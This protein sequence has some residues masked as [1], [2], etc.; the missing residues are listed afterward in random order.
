MKVENI[1]KEIINI[2]PIDINNFVETFE[3]PIRGHLFEKLFDLMQRINFIKELEEYQP[4]YGNFGNTNF[5]GSVDIN[6]LNFLNENIHNGNKSGAI[7]AI[8][9]NKKEKKIIAL[10]FKFF[11]KGEP[12]YFKDYDINGMIGAAKNDLQNEFKD[13]EISFG[14]VTNCL[15]KGLKKKFEKTATKSKH[16]VD[17][18]FANPEI[19][20]YFK[21]FVKFILDNK[22]NLTESFLNKT[23]EKKSNIKLR[24]YQDYGYKCL[25]KIFKRYNQALLGALPRFGKTLVF[26]KMM[27]DYNKILYISRVVSNIKEDLVEFIKNNEDFDKY[28][29]SVYDNGEILSKLELEEKH[30]VI[31]SVQSFQKLES[32][33]KFDLIIIDEAHIGTTTENFQQL[34]KTLCKTNTKILFVTATFKKPQMGYDLN[35][36]QCFFFGLSDVAKLHKDNRNKFQGQELIQKIE[37]VLNRKITDTEFDEL[38]YPVIH[39]LNLNIPE[40]IIKEFDEFDKNE[41]TF[42]KNMFKCDDKGFT[43]QGKEGITNILDILFKKNIERISGNKHLMT[44]INNDLNLV[45]FKNKMIIIYVPGGSEEMRSKNVCKNLAELINSRYDKNLYKCIVVPEKEIKKNINYSLEEDKILI[46]ISHKKIQTAITFETC[47]GVVFLDDSKSE[48]ELTQKMY[49]PATWTQGKDN[50]FIIDTNPCRITNILLEYGLQTNQFKSLDNEALVYLKL[51]DTLFHIS[52]NEFNIN[53]KDLYFQEIIDKYI[54]N[55]SVNNLKNNI[56]NSTIM[57]QQKFDLFSNNLNTKNKVEI[58]SRIEDFENKKAIREKV[59]EK[60]ESDEDNIETNDEITQ[61]L[62]KT[63]EYKKMINHILFIIMFSKAK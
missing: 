31:S 15:T 53:E 52:G 13:Y 24:Y 36:S 38:K 45:N 6:I 2:K 14:I 23:N 5:N 58:K 1:I 43:N 54:S 4:I 3:T 22:N 27:T 61:N 25:T 17:Y 35:D 20:I 8:F 32:K 63:R 42:F 29:T 19:N 34:L 10:S 44:K 9:I 46:V 37:K 50:V 18:Y 21:N 40:N 49:R 56:V 33:K 26:G 30:I 47:I 60:T 59:G 11:K 28:E 62:I 41:I 12:K 51:I 55:L 7:D 39:P 57:T 16:E 48:D